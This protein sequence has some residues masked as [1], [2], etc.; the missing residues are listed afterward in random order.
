LLD[1]QL[2]PSWQL[3]AISLKARQHAQSISQGRYTNW[4]LA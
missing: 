3:S 1:P 2:T 4:L